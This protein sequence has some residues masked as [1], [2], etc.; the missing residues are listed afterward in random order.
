MQF[1]GGFPTHFLIV[2]LPAPSTSCGIIAKLG[3]V[4]ENREAAD[5]MGLALVHSRAGV[6]VAAP[7]VN[8][9]VHLGG[10]LPRMS[11]VGLPETALREAKDRVKAALLNA[12]FDFPAKLI[13]IS[14]TPAVLP[15][16][17]SRFDLPIALGILAASRQVPDDKFKQFEF[18]GELSLSGELNPVK[19]VL[20]VAL[21]AKEAGRGL[22]V[23]RGNGAEAALAKGPRQFEASSLLSVVA[24]LHDKEELPT[25]V[26]N[27][28]TT[29]RRCKD[30]ADVVGQPFAR[31]ALEVAAAGGHNILLL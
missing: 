28:Y 30:M 3:I 14:L 16:E 26:A 25:T 17:G 11:L 8:V 19:G 7:A 27:S 31:R 24:W 23:P 20:P 10:G 22:I 6:G 1:A 4:L 5:W 18:I 29:V 2:F 15:K 9:E 21:R 13:T 12:N